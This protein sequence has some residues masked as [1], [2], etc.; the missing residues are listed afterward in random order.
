MIKMHAVL[1][2][3]SFTVE[4]D[5]AT[6]AD[7]EVIKPLFFVWVSAQA[8]QSPEVQALVDRMRQ[9]RERLTRVIE[10]VSRSGSTQ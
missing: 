7:L 8:D 6:L 10:T 3:N 2:D 5:T 4:S 1:G 9:S